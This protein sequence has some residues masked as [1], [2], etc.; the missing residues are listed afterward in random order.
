MFDRTRHT[1]QPVSGESL[2]NLA[3]L[4]DRI[5]DLESRRAT[6]SWS[7]T[8]TRRR[9]YFLSDLVPGAADTPRDAAIALAKRHFAY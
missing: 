7:V 6:A 3:T 5:L 4:V 1:E 9:V 8:A 2:G